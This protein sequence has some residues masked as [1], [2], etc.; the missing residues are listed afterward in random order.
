VYLLIRVTAVDVCEAADD[1]S[2]TTAWVIEYFD[3]F[4]TEF[5]VIL[6]EQ[7]KKQTFFD[8]RTFLNTSFQ[9]I[10]HIY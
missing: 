10:S 8:E 6:R 1:D 2:S 9:P 5:Q 7:A 4:Q 3:S